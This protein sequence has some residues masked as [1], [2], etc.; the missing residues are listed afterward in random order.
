[1]DSVTGWQLRPGLIYAGKARLV[2]ALIKAKVNVNKAKDQGMLK[3][4]PR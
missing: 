1:M 3:Q 2:F 4:S